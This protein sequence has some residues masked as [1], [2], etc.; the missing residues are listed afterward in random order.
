MESS[1]LVSLLPRFAAFAFVLYFGY[2][3]F[4]VPFFFSPLRRIPRAHWS[5]PFPYVGSLWMLYQRYQSR[6]NTVTYEAHQKLGPVVRLGDNEISVNCYDGGLRTI[7]AGGWEKHE[8]YPRQFANFGV[9]NMFST[10]GHTPHAQKKRIMANI[11]SKTYLQNSAQVQANSQELLSKRFLPL[12]ES[13]AETREACD[14]HEMNNAF[15]MDFMTAYQFGISRSTNFTQDV[16][17]RRKYLHL[18]HS[19]REWQFISSEVPPVIRRT[20]QRLGLSL[21]PAF[22]HKANAWLEDWSRNMCDAA[23]GYLKQLQGSMQSCD[24][25]PGDQPV[26]FR[27]YKTGLMNLRS[28]EPT[29]GVELH[30]H[31]DE[32]MN[33]SGLLNAGKTTI[34]DETTTTLEVYSDMVDQL[35]AGHETSALALTYLNYELSRNPAM[36]DRLHTEIHTLEPRITWPS[37]ITDLPTPKQIDALPYLN[38]LVLETLRL[39]API[40]GMQPRIS[41]SQ[42]GGAS[43]GPPNTANH[44][45]GIPAN[46]RVSAMPYTLHRIQSIFPEPDKFNPDRWFTI[47]QGGKTSDEQMTEMNR[48]FWAFGSGGRMCIGSHLALQEIKL[49]VCAIYGNFKTEIVDDEGIEEMDAYTTRP[50]SGKLILR[51]IRR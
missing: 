1:L 18:Y 38:A 4:I 24:V 33:F 51:F 14:V 29:A 41:P 6:N 13:L 27:Q 19:R 9:M 36:Q 2:N 45:T 17:V 10:V 43:L 3:F 12:I 34:P 39:H 32:G 5:V 7:Y 42:P 15:T 46:V 40:P 44:Y 30:P 23:D 28:K 22:I 49:I 21:Y 31:L 26:V 20:L 47:S 16:E 35:A 50:K 11:Y 37:E 8:W 25:N 48:H